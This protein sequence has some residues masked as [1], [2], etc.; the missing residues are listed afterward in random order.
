M[1]AEP[2]SDEVLF[3]C[4]SSFLPALLRQISFEITNTV[5]MLAD[6]GCPLGVWRFC[7][8][9]LSPS[10]MLGSV[11]QKY[12]CFPPLP[13]A[14]LSPHP[15]FLTPLFINNFNIVQSGSKQETLLF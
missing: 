15:P 2:G 14:D 3:L 6:F 7:I 9:M 5:G 8:R 4:L 1:A 11:I 10:F 12:P 13:P